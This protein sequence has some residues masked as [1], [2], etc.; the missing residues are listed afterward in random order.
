MSTASMTEDKSCYGGVRIG[1]G[2]V[3]FNATWPFAKIRI[4]ESEI[5]LAC[6]FEEWIF[7]KNSV[8]CISSHSGLL[9]NGLRIEH[10]IPDYNP[11]IAFL[12]SKSFSLQEIFRK[13]GYEVR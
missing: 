2:L 6:L 1:E 11:Y 5:R 7:P 12:T 10:T 4:G 9:S 13:K 8:R 3:A